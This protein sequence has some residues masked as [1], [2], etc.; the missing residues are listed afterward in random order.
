[1]VKSVKFR[2]NRGRARVNSRDFRR[3]RFKITHS[4]KRVGE[5]AFSSP[6]ICRKTANALKKNDAYLARAKNDRPWRGHFRAWLLLL[7]LFFSRKERERERENLRKERDGTYHGDRSKFSWVLEWGV[8]AKKR[9]RRE[10]KKQ[11]KVIYENE[12]KKAKTTKKAN[13]NP[14]GIS[15]G[16]QN[17]GNW[18]PSLFKHT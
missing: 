6:K 4:F 12:W 13:N 10:R 5:R 8:D 9:E 1:M 7:F 14:R 18:I 17:K 2:E 3:L 16:E 15:V 11:K